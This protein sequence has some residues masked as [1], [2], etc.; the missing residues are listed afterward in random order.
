MT[1]VS[2]YF[3]NGRKQITLDRTKFL[4]LARYWQL[5][6]ALLYDLY[7]RSVFVKC[8][9]CHTSAPYYVSVTTMAMGTGD[10]GYWYILLIYRERAKFGVLD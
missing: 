8:S 10:N 6:L 3:A 2:F 5:L 7:V 4:I 1:G 9:L